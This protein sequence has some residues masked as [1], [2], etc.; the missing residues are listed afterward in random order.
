MTPN[1]PT[2]QRPNDAL[3]DLIGRRVEV[4]SNSGDDEH[5]D[6]GVLEAFDHPFVRLNDNGKILCFSIFN[7]RLIKLLERQPSGNFLAN[8][9]LRPSQPADR[10]PAQLL[11]PQPSEEIAE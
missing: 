5:S 2:T 4:W 10:D 9:L 7:V 8:T 11:R 6:R 3:S 1:D